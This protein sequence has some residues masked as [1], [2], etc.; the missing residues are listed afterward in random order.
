[1]SLSSFI[2]IV[3]IYSRIKGKIKPI[4]HTQRDMHA[5]SYGNQHI[6]AYITTIYTNHM[7]FTGAHTHHKTTF[8]L[9]L[10]SCLHIDLSFPPEIAEGFIEPN[11]PT[12]EGP[13]A[14][15]EKNPKAAFGALI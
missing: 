8:Q 14:G 12:R 3:F 13:T 9:K 11:S 6:N 2:Q 10:Q 7:L 1:M 4:A 5:V 15:T